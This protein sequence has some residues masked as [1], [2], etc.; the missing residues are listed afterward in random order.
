MRRDR[1][2]VVGDDCE[3]VDGMKRKTS[4]NPIESVV[5]VLGEHGW[6][7]DGQTAQQ[8]VRIPTSRSPVFGGVGGKVAT[9]GGRR[10]FRRGETFCTV[11][12]RTVN[13]YERD[14]RGPRNMRQAATKDIDRVKELA[15]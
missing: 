8:T 3:G 9:F 12:A 1:R 11:G 15:R 6:L 10:R 5:A 7:V 4:P 13:F 2:G 14:E